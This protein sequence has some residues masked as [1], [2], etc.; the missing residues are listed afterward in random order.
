MATVETKRYTAEEFWEWWAQSGKPGTRYEL[1]RGVIVEV[2]PP[3]E[4]HGI[5]CCLIAYLLG[6]Y[7]FQRGKGFACTNDTGLLVGRNPDTVRGPDV[8]VFDETLSIDDASPKFST[9]VPKLIVEVIS[10]TD[11]VGNT[12]KRIHQYFERGVPLV[13]LVDPEIRLVTV[14]RPGQEP[15]PIEE[16]G[17]VSADDVLPGC[18]FRVA[19]FFRLPGE[20][21]GNDGAAN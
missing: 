18:K 13:W 12:L 10:P 8:M 17:E 9:R 1:D 4:L 20:S 14:H 3:G 21:N 11:R 5:V 2:P 16:D 7:L 15:T 6:Q 19:E